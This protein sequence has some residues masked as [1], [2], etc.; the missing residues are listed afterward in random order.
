MGQIH[1]LW[2]E[3]APRGSR[4]ACAAAPAA[5]RRGADLPSA[6]P[7]SA[8]AAAPPSSSPPK[9][10]ACSR[11]MVCEAADAER[12]SGW[13]SQSSLGDRSK[14]DFERIHPHLRSLACGTMNLQR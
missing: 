8:A 6:A 11:V 9:A 3:Q 1:A 14:M 12:V 7:R 10:R 4:T 2:F 13:D 5:P